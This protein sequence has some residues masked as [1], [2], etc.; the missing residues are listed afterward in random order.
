MSNLRNS[1]SELPNIARYWWLNCIVRCKYLDVSRLWECEAST[2][3]ARGPQPSY[4]MSISNKHFMWFL[5]YHSLNIPTPTNCSNCMDWDIPYIQTN[6]AARSAFPTRNMPHNHNFSSRIVASL[7]TRHGLFL[8]C[9]LKVEEG[10]C[11]KLKTKSF[12]H[13]IL[14]VTHFPLDSGMLKRPYFQFRTTTFFKFQ[15]T[16]DK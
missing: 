14:T 11:S 13:Y 16:Y 15:Q 6:D 1:L 12:Q 9:L 10:C 7:F 2:K 8:I 4:Q 3:M 5:S